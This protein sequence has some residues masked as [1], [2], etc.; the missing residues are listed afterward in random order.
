MS[1]S[2]SVFSDLGGGARLPSFAGVRDSS[3]LTPNGRHRLVPGR[4]G[5]QQGTPVRADH[6]PRG[7]ITSRLSREGR[8]DDS[9]ASLGPGEGGMER[10]HTSDPRVTFFLG[11]RGS[12]VGLVD[13]LFF[14]GVG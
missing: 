14:F 3:R 1:F 11:W 13:F 7:G 8:H 10:G 12:S 4:R 6:P 9:H 2:H 5:R